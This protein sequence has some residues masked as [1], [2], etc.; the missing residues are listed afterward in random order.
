[1]PFSWKA[2]TISIWTHGYLCRLFFSTCINIRSQ[3]IQVFFYCFQAKWF[4][5]K[6]QWTASKIKNN[7]KNNAK[8]WKM[9]DITLI[10]ESTAEIKAAKDH[11]EQ[12]L[13]KAKKSFRNSWNDS[14]VYS[15]CY[16]APINF[17]Q[18]CLYAVVV[19]VADVVD[20]WPWWPLQADMCWVCESNRSKW[21]C[22]RHQLN[23]N[24]CM[25]HKI[26]RK[27]NNNNKL[28]Q[29]Q[30]ELIRNTD[31]YRTSISSQRNIVALDGGSMQTFY[32]F[33][34]IFLSSIVC[35]S[36]LDAC[37]CDIF[38]LLSQGSI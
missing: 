1:M 22:I 24:L 18:T 32:N 35:F 29:K 17:R 13:P 2:S 37:D 19:V 10:L 38:V 28:W 21:K 34:G 31:E 11:L 36:V 14:S 12:W 23:S 33:F 6:L 27:R 20:F 15:F 3:F 26:R 9:N 7:M 16:L 4:N 8:R 25:A 5:V 30:K